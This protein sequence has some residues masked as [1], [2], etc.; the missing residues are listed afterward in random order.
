MKTKL[1]R[2]DQRLLEGL[3]LFVVLSAGLAAVLG[4][5]DA[6]TEDSITAP[7]Q[8]DGTE[9]IGTA[10]GQHL[11]V[12]TATLTV[13]DP[14]LGERLLVGVPPAVGALMAA[15]VAT[16]LLEVVR[17]LRLGDPF[18]HRNARLRP[19]PPLSRSAVV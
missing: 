17:S 13:D 11:E 15:A 3:L 1:T 7:V 9:V 10:P 2:W 4:T 5:I 16:I 6:M 18:H 19:P 12:D 14:S 8:L